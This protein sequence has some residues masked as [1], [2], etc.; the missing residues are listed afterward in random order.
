M[1]KRSSTIESAVHRDIPVTTVARTLVDLAS[2]LS[3]TDLASACHEAGVKYETTP[4]QVEAVLA[5]HPTACGASKLRRVMHGD[6]PVTQSALE[7]RFLRLLVEHG[8]PLPVTNK[9]AGSF[10]VDCRWPEVPLTVELDGYR[11]H[12][13]RHAWERDRR[14]ER[15]ARARGDRFRRYMY[16]DVYEN[17][18]YMVR[19]LSSLLRKRAA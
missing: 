12:G 17:S 3:L 1:T 7:S 2:S 19:E 6:A 9:P 5:Q 11:Y 10:R 8:L 18:R 15:E 13:S 4:R 16:G 14:R